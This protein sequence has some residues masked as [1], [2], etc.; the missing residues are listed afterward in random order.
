MFLLFGFAVMTPVWGQSGNSIQKQIFDDY[1][2]R[3]FSAT[4]EP[5]GLKEA[6]AKLLMAVRRANMQSFLVSAAKNMPGARIELN[7]FGA[8]K[9]FLR[10]GNSL[11]APS[12]LA[13]EEI[14]KNFLLQNSTAY[15]FTPFEVDSLRIVGKDITKNATFLTFSQT[16][17]G[18]DVFN[19]HIKFT[20][21]NR[22][23]VIQVGTG[24]VAPG[25]RV[26]TTPRLS[27]EEAIKAAFVSLSADRP[28][29][30]TPMP[31]ENGKAK[32]VN[33]KGGHYNPI[34]A[35]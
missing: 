20:L 14:A 21:N 11:S 34:T 32:Y 5:T 31:S 13:P 7:R 25:I 4:A 23:E 27:A 30:L 1:D 12:M 24:D 16:I 6:E 3:D 33:P 19:G 22:G 8:P 26:S 29:R 15:S 28:A 9:L 35:E 2:S 18:I 10:D 17:D